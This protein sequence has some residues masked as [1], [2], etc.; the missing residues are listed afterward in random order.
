[1]ASITLNGLTYADDGTVT[2]T[3][4][5]GGRRSYLVP[6]A[7]DAVAD[8]LSK[9]NAAAA[10]VATI[11][12]EQPNAAQAAGGAI[13]GTSTTSLTVGSGAK[14]LTVQ[15]GRAFVP[16]QWVAVA[17]GVNPTTI[18]MLG[19][20]TGYTSGTG[21]LTVDVRSYA[22][23]GTLAAWAVRVVP[24]PAS[25][26]VA[27]RAANYTLIGSDRGSM[28]DFTATASC[29]FTSAATL[30]AGWYCYIRN[31]GTGEVTLDPFGTELID[32]LQFYKMYPGE[33][34]LVTC[35]GTAFQT[36]ILSPFTVTFTTSGTWTK[37]PGYSVF[38]A[39][40]LGGGGGGAAGT[41]GAAG[42][43]RPGGCG[44]G[45]GALS[46]IHI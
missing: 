26:P 38:L 28:Q 42:T 30:G 20:V 31:T 32:G 24:A 16:G 34:R 33:C 41:V 25:R 27:N 11:T 2:R 10:S 45:G 18:F 37:P 3:I 15:T 4:T 8:L 44:G 22:G 39:E 43:N 1:M 35:T 12:A 19:V 46:L 40:C 36:E 21:S 14:T 5:G 13:N 29:I 17:D 23:S 6:F 7:S 9:Q